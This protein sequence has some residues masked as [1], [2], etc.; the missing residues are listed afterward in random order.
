MEVLWWVRTGLP[1]A[2][3]GGLDSRSPM[4][5]VRCMSGTTAPVQERASFHAMTD[6]TQEDWQK[7]ATSAMAFYPGLT[8]R[9][10]RHLAL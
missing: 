3:I 1:P 7:I 9:V 5:Q 6:G 8:D 4:G 10:M 2:I